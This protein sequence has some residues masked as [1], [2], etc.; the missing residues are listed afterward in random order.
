MSIN[1]NTNIS[2]FVGFSPRV[3]KTTFG[4]SAPTSTVGYNSGDEVWVTSNGTST[5]TVTA[6][7]RFDGV[8]G[9]WV[10]YLS[11]TSTPLTPNLV[12]VLD[13]LDTPPA[14][15]TDQDSYIVKEVATGAWAGK[16]GDIAT[17][18]YTQNM[19]IFYSPT[20]GQ[21][22]SVLTG[23]NIGTWTYQA[24][25]DSWIQTSTTPTTV[26]T[27][28]RPTAK[29]M[30]FY[31]SRDNNIQLN[32]VTYYIYGDSIAVTTYQTAGLLGSG[33]GTNSGGFVHKVPYIWS[34][35]QS[36]SLKNT[37][38]YAPKFVDGAWGYDYHLA[39]DS[40]GKLWC[41]GSAQLGTGLTTTATGTTSLTPSIYGFTPIPFFQNLNN[42]IICGVYTN[43]Y[44]A[45]VNVGFSAVLTTD[46]KVYVTGKNTSGNLG[47]GNTTDVVNWIQYPIT[48]VKRVKLSSNG[49]FTLT[50]TGDL[51]Y[52][53]GDSGFGGST[54]NK[55]TPI[56]IKNNVADFD[57]SG[58][59][60]TE[61][62]IIACNDGTLWNGG[63]NTSGQ[64]GRG[65]TTNI[66]G[67]TQ[68]SGIT[69]AKFVFGG[70]DNAN[71]Y[72]GTAYVNSS[73]K[74][75]FAG[76]N[77]NGRLGVGTINVNVLTYTA[78]TGY[79]Q[80]KVQKLTIGRTTTTVQTIDG[81]LWNVGEMTYRGLG[82]LSGNATDLM[83]WARVPIRGTVVDYT[84]FFDSSSTENVYVLSDKGMYTYGS[85]SSARWNP[86]AGSSVAQYSPT[87]L[88]Q[89]VSESDAIS[90]PPAY[91]LDKVGD[92]TQAT[93]VSVT[94]IVDNKNSQ[95]VTFTFTLD[96]GTNG[97]VDISGS[98]IT[99]L[100]T[101]QVA[102]L[103]NSLV[104]VVPGQQVSVS[105]TID[106]QDSPTVAIPNSEP[107][108]WVLDLM[109]NGL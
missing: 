94:S 32:A 71:G 9:Q 30:A 48:N 58:R 19:W 62:V 45:A 90:E 105:F 89:W 8:T 39:L 43:S 5:G 108:D 68:V 83:T 96:D 56:L 81:Q 106:A 60:G 75:F 3:E 101:T 27:S 31:R 93:P 59:A 16:E 72:L 63:T 2:K 107:Q 53:G 103:T 78:P 104:Y 41:G 86:G 91:V 46:G 65:N 20:D 50:L 54:T 88:Q 24:S 61:A 67:V 11:G 35:L 109:V 57:W 26:D 49:I 18:D 36:G 13:I 15:P 25:T 42:V 37:V 12:P 33:D 10:K 80:N 17:W 14:T 82:T 6:V 52:S 74:V 69:D 38:T 64:L 76:N 102:Q 85:S 98:T 22:T 34:N 73:L 4:S 99:G 44:K 97:L 95:T 28:A 51:Y 21:K 79:I 29:N 84:I 87:Y 7:Y 55:T 92:I 47:N 23:T 1:V 77:I 70:K 66:T 40:R 100:Y